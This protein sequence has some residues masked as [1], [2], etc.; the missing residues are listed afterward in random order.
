MARPA[1]PRRAHG[2][3]AADSARARR[4]ARGGRL[5]CAATPIALIERRSAPL[6]LALAPRSAAATPSGRAAG[7]ARMPRG[8]RRAVLRRT[9]GRSARMLRPQAEEALGEL[10]ALGLVTSDSFAG[11]RALL[12]PSSQRKPLA[13]AQR[14]GRVLPFDIESGGRWSLIRRAAARGRGRTALT[15]GRACGPRAAR[16]A[17]ASSSG[18]CCARSPAGCRRGATFCASTAG[19]KRAARFAA[20]DSSRAFPASSSRCLKRSASCARCA[21]SP[22]SGEWVSLSGADPLNLIG[23]LTP[24]QQA[25]RAHRQSHRLSRRTADRSA[26][27]RA[28]PSC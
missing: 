3:G 16:A 8:A 2:L 13:G 12:V 25:R 20:A 24:G 4:A 21:A 26:F 11:L 9:C 1:M 28:K 7:S 23:V 14:R 6:W 5:R 10:V 27:R 18:A 17:T 19:S 15:R 22:R